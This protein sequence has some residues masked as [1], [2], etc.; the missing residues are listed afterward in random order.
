MT[1][2]VTIMD[3]RLAALDRALALNAERN[4]KVGHI[5]DTAAK[6][7]AYLSEGTVPSLD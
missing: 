7:E 3:L 2:L 6:F 4:T 5:L 1:T